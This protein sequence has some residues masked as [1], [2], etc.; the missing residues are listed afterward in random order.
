MNSHQP[1]SK[2][3]SDGRKRTARAATAWE[4]LTS[5]RDVAPAG[6]PLPSPALT[7]HT[8]ALR[9]GATA[10]GRLRLQATC[11][12]IASGYLQGEPMARFFTSQFPYDGEQLDSALSRGELDWPGHQCG[13]DQIR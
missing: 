12:A 2:K 3:S 10:V 6:V 1:L 7:P 13:M 5:P 11:E 4:W 8:L 9:F